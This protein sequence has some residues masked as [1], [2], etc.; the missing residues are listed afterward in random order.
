[1]LL[2][3]DFDAPLI[4]MG[5]W[6][7]FPDLNLNRYMT[8]VVVTLCDIQGV[9]HKMLSSVRVFFLFFF[10]LR[11]LLL[12]PVQWVG[13]LILWGS[14]NHSVETPTWSRNDSSSNSPVKW[15]SSLGREFSWPV[16]PSWFMLHGAGKHSL[17]NL[18]QSADLGEKQMI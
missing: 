15:V 6:S 10:S 14:R 8:L 1:M 11:Q 2:E 4:E 7:L 5:G 9:R 18:I 12:E 16:T 13:S 3:C 17:M